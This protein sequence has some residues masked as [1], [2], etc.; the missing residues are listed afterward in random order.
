MYERIVVS[1]YHTAIES[2]EVAQL[3]EVISLGVLSLKK[4]IKLS[5]PNVLRF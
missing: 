1:P 4:R 2:V 3:T 5:L